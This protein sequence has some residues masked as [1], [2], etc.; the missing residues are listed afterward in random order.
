[1]SSAQRFRLGVSTCGRFLILAR[2]GRSV[3]RRMPTYRGLE[4]SIVSEGVDLEEYNVRVHGGKIVTAHIESE[5]GKEFVYEYCNSLQTTIAIETTIDGS[6]IPSII[7]CQPGMTGYDVGHCITRHEVR[8]YKFA[9]IAVTSDQ[10][11]EDGASS[12]GVIELRMFRVKNVTF[13]SDLEE[14][15]SETEFEPIDGHTPGDSRRRHHIALGKSRDVLDDHPWERPIK[16][17]DYLD[18]R[19]NPFVIFRFLYRPRGMRNPLVFH[20]TNLQITV[21]EQRCW[22][23]SSARHQVQH[24]H[25]QLLRGSKNRGKAIGIVSASQRR[26]TCLPERP[27]PI[28]DVQPGLGSREQAPYSRRTR[29]SR[30]PTL[31]PNKGASRLQESAPIGKPGSRK[32]VVHIPRTLHPLKTFFVRALTAQMISERN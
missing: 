24:H 25:A 1:M 6:R 30:S 27:N 22:K 26:R 5:A 21:M 29:R 32:N 2:L 16:E 19:D 23:G 15:E 10:P 12:I 17:C 4:V 11:N 31:S 3:S 20:L 14:S 8:P 18:K 9:E 28:L 13:A 7:H